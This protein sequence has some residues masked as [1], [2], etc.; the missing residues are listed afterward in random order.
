MGELAEARKA[1]GRPGG[2]GLLLVRG[3][4]VRPRRVGQCATS[5]PQVPV[6]PPELLKT[7][8]PVFKGSKRSAD[9]RGV[10]N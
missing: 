2:E 10:T 7:Q 4:Q 8:Y 3:V 9:Y 1:M 6:L 5:P